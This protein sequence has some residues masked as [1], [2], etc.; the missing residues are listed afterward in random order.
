MVSGGRREQETL[1]GKFFS[2][3]FF[4]WKCLRK[5][6]RPFPEA[7]KDAGI[8]GDG[9][10]SAYLFG[11]DPTLTEAILGN[12]LKALLRFKL[13][14]AQFCTGNPFGPLVMNDRNPTLS[15]K[16]KAM[17]RQLRRLRIVS[18]RHCWVQ[19]L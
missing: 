4:I 15:Q 9:N 10:Y 17:L 1:S 19:G 2:K 13:C 6:C 18:C 3:T 5:F 7:V 8:L 12:Y 16:G 11:K 14:M